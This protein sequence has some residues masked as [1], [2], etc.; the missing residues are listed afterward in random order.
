MKPNKKQ[1]ENLES[2]I[3][4]ATKWMYIDEE[5]YLNIRILEEALNHRNIG[6]K[7]LR[8]Q[9]VINWLKELWK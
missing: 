5:I 3:A 2:S 1:I 9:D 6:T 4:I 7:L 8:V